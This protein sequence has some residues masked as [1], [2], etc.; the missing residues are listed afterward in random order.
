[1]RTLADAGFLQPAGKGL[2]RNLVG[3]RYQASAR[4]YILLPRVLG[5]MRPRRVSDADRFS[6]TYL[7]QLSALLQEELGRGWIST[8]RATRVCRRRHE[9]RDTAQRDGPRPA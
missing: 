5:R 9:E 8:R 2:K 1:M 3:R 6:A 4:S 7:M